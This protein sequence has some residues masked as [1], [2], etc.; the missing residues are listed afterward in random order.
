MALKEDAGV[1]GCNARIRP[2]CDGR[3]AS[4]GDAARALGADHGNTVGGKPVSVL[5]GKVTI[6]D[7]R[8][9]SD[10]RTSCR[11]PSNF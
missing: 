10:R 8:Y 9:R 1:D 2:A 11:R 7:C 4:K 6:D 3:R 5:D